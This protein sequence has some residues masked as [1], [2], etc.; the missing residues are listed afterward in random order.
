MLLKSIT[1]EE[2]YMLIQKKS[3]G[4]HVML[5]EHKNDSSIQAEIQIISIDS[6]NI[7][8]A[9]FTLTYQQHTLGMDI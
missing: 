8:E 4:L 5:Y 3:F 7:L 6:K 1:S 9:D 2:I